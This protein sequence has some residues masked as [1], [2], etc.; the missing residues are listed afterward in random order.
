M[1]GRVRVFPLKQILITSLGNTLEWFDFA[2][3]IF[4]APII[5]ENFFPIQDKFL[6]MLSVFGVFAA[7]FICRPLGGI[8]FGHA[9]D[10]HGRA[11]ALRISILIIS[12]S[13]LLVGLLPSYHS[14]GIL[15]SL[16]FIFLRLMQGISIGGE[17]SGVMIYLAESTPKSSRGLT[18]SFAAIGANIGF[19]MATFTL[20]MID[21]Y[22][23]KETTQAWIW[24]VPFIFIGAVGLILVYFRFQLQET[25]TFT[26]LKTTHHIEHYPLLSALKWAPKSL[27][28]IF[29]L[30][31]AGS[32][33]Y[34]VFFGYMPHYLES[35]HGK[36]IWGIE[37]FFLAFM[38]FI[39]P[40]AGM[41]GDRYGRKRMLMLTYS[42]LLLLIIPCFYLLYNQATS[43]MIFAFFIATTL[44]S[45]DQGNTLAAIVENCPSNVRY[46]GIAFSY[47]LGNAIFGGT[48]P[49]IVALLTEK[50]GPSVPSYYLIFMAML[51]L[52]ASLTLSDKNELSACT[53][54]DSV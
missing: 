13:T 20:L 22:I 3:F 29:G 39:V 2:L 30:T 51:S 41:C 23:A 48:A 1:V 24:R 15:A 45:F 54:V 28:K 17:Y 14:I 7:G 37:N 32:T 21:T 40:L 36:S 25:P 49:L 9:G 38:L 4:F 26:E 53:L 35:V 16:A 47:N 5:G 42:L 18:T 50:V 12:L 33:L 27:L 8:L 10:T 6:S 46:S 52:I 43:A 11:K 34:Y 19:L 31:C 44:S